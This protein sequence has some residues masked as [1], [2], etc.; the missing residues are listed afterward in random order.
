M[1]SLQTCLLAGEATAAITLLKGCGIIGLGKEI[2]SS[3][4]LKAM[5]LINPLSSLMA[6]MRMIQMR[7]LGNDILEHALR[8]WS[9][10]VRHFFHRLGSLSSC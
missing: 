9:R 1:T 3:Q 8:S 5:Y 6:A 7:H 4:G 2:T 10:V